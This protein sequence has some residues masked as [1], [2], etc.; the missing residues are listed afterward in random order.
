MS[1]SA[2]T[3]HTA[4]RSIEGLLKETPFKLRLLAQALGGLTSEE[5]KMAWH[6]LNTNESRAEHIL[7]LL[8]GWDQANPGAARAPMT[9]GATPHTAPQQQA[10]PQQQQFPVPGTAQQYP[11]P[12]QQQQFPQQAPQQQFQPQGVQQMA[13]V[14][15]AAV[16]PQAA[17]AAAAATEKPS[18]RKP[19][20]TSANGAPPVDADVAGQVVAM[21]QTILTG[22]GTDA[23]RFQQLQANITGILEEASTAKLG[24][25][26]ALEAKYGEVA[27][28]L[29]HLSGAVQA[30]SQIQVWT[31]MAFLTFMQE[32]MGASMK[33]IL[34]AAIQDSAMF[35]KL[36]DQ[37]T[38]KAQ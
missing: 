11:A 25:V 15:P 20:T 10:Q 18:G 21:L 22:L 3:P 12:Q 28:S 32:Q 5:Q 13:P 14:G 16:S 17:A 35:Q 26:T 19:R 8:K 31:L 29:Q 9:N 23:E 1:E 4:P 33:D 6:Q 38:G 2:L 24:R 34:G 27:S 37:A 7:A 30:Q 36:V